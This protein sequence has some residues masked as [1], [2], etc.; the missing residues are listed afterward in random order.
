M[1][2]ATFPTLDLNDGRKIPILGLGCM[3]NVNEKSL[4]RDSV[5]EAIRQGYRHFDTAYLYGTEQLVGE[6]INKAI[7]EGLVTR[8]EIFV[9]TKVWLFNLKRDDLIAQAKESN[10]NLGLGYIDLLLIHGAFA[11]HKPDPTLVFPA[12][13]FPFKKDGK[14]DVD[15]DVDIV[16]ESWPAMEEVVRLGIVK[17]IGV[18]NW[19]VPMLEQV[20][21]S[22]SI[23]PA[24]NQIECNPFFQQKEIID[25][26]KKNSIV[27][28]A[29]SPFGGA[30]PAPR[31]GLPSDTDSDKQQNRPLLWSDPTIT[32]IAEKHGKTVSQIL[33]KFHVARKVTVIPKTIK[34]ERLI[35]NS[36]IFDFE[37]DEEDTEKLNALDSGHSCAPEFW[38]RLNA[39]GGRQD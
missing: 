16:K 11:V 26:C 18:S 21:A 36:N 15:L 27:V 38:R 30:P 28:T 8:E 9:T 22:A 37:L 25:C 3:E 13:F 1:S 6:G 24:V 2:A 32:A 4:V 33:L 7:A 23:K 5:Y 12:N 35:E 34:K 31:P 17:S 29:Y 19:H 14:V 10:N 39:T 20:C